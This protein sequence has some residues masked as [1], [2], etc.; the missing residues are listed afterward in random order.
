MAQM[1]LTTVYI[2]SFTLS[3]Y[4]LCILHATATLQFTTF[5]ESTLNYSA[6]ECSKL[7]RGALG[8]S[9]LDCGPHTT[10]F[11]LVSQQWNWMKWTFGCSA[12]ESDELECSALNWGA[13]Y[14][15]ALDYSAFD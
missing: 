12:L 1:K 8:C 3:T 14:C 2:Y 11:L 6:L 9:A 10:N 15:S 4:D 13:L 5:I 7:E